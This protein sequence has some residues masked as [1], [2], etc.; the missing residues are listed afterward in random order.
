MYRTN[1]IFLMLIV[2][3]TCVARLSGQTPE[4]QAYQR[5]ISTYAGLSNCSVSTVTSFYAR[6]SDHRPQRVMY[7]QAKFSEQGSIIKN[8]A[9]EV[10]T[11]GHCILV[12]D[13]A[14]KTMQY[15]KANPAA[16]KQSLD[17]QRQAFAFAD[18]LFRAR[19]KVTLSILAD[20]TLQL[21]AKP[22][23]T[24]NGPEQTTMLFDMKTH[25]LS[26]VTYLYGAGS[27]YYRVETVYEHADL[28]PFFP[29]GT[30][31]ES[32][33][34]SGSGE[35]AKPQQKYA[36]YTFHNSFSK[37]LNLYDDAK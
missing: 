27:M 2:G 24:G 32:R 37:T 4:E 36:A 26:K 23:K 29:N 30:F 21:V 16:L 10:L 34:V 35:K 19:N 6:Q 11:N 3:F 14:E 25:S 8:D 17:R 31:S 7:S 1:L 18:S 33:Y 20:S 15:S 12:M 13:H 22:H 5:I 28:A 9:V